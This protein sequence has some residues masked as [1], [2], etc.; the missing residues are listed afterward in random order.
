MS[1]GE[2]DVRCV[3]GP[4]G[5][6]KTTHVAKVATEAARRFGSDKVVISS[7]TRAAA[8]EVASRRVPIPKEA[9]GTMHALAY[10][11]LGRPGLVGD[12]EAAEWNVGRCPWAGSDGQRCG[13]HAA[14]PISGLKG[15]FSALKAG[16]DHR[17][18]D[19]GEKLEG[20]R[21][22]EKS[23]FY[24]SRLMDRKDWP[25]ESALF[26]EHWAAWKEERG[27]V[28]FQ[29]MITLALR[30]CDQAPGN[31]RILYVD[32]GQDSSTAEIALAMKWGRAAG[33]LVAVGDPDQS[34]YGWRG[35]DPE[36]FLRMATGEHRRV[37]EQSYRVPRAVHAQA[38]QWIE[39]L[40]RYGR[41][42]VVY[43]PR[44]EDGEV[45][46]RGDLHA[47]YPAGIL[48][49]VLRDVERG[50]TVMILATCGYMLQPLQRLLKEEALPFWNPYRPRRGDWNPLSGTATRVLNYLAPDE[51][52]WEDNARPWTWKRLWSWL[53]LIDSKL[54]A[55]GAKAE[56]KRLGTTEETAELPVCGSLVQ[57]AAALDA[58]FADG[59]NTW[60]G[61][62]TWLRGLLL[63]TATK[64]MEYPIAVAEKHG[65]KAL[66]DDPKIVIGTVHSTKGS[67]SDAV[68]L[69]PDLSMSAVDEWQTPEGE[70]AIRRLFYVGMTRAREKLVICGSRGRRVPEL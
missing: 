42:R 39:Q 43:N 45:D 3:I 50:R 31:P 6:G 22:L 37:L 65:G 38:V 13:G 54:L 36:A 4:P 5:T 68:Y 53:E 2:F 52:T 21:L 14:W 29:D 35:A 1:Q 17:N 59:M 34:I 49:E 30:D 63:E 20:D 25:N 44:D 12:E 51:R 69:L 60:D 46:R 24:R 26:D 10:R 23:T 62:P 41:E 16:D 8:H 66:R 40:G 7:L 47:G 70:T 18:D 15:G 33:H 56:C 61:N 57:C 9:V 64:K 55:N 11:A 19:R 28:D 67:E 48:G 32:E 27:V 58:I